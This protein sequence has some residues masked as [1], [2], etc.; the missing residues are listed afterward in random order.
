MN[1]ALTDEVR[2]FFYAWSSILLQDCSGLCLH[3]FVLRKEMGRRVLFQQAAVFFFGSF[4][5][6][7]KTEV[8]D[9]YHAH[10]F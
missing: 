2:A 5:N 1:R 4:V 10:N 7:S 3:S 9:K 8:S 6:L